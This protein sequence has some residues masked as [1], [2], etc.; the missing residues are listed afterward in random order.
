MIAYWDA[1]SLYPSQMLNYLPIGGFRVEEHANHTAYLY[2]LIDSFNPEN[3]KG[4]LICADMYV[5]AHQHDKLD[6]G[7][8][9]RGPTCEGGPNKLYSYLGPQDEYCLTL[10]LAHCYHTVLG[11]RFK[12]VHRIWR[13]RQAPY[14]REHILEMCAR[15]A[16][17]ESEIMKDTF[18]KCQNSYYGCTSENHEKRMSIVP[19]TNEYEFEQANAKNWRPGLKIEV[20]YHYPNGDFLGHRECRPKGGVELRTPRIVAVAILDYAKRHLLQF[21]YGFVKLNFGNDARL[22]YTDTDSIIVRIANVRSVHEA[23]LRDPSWFDF[24]NGRKLGWTESPEN[25]G[26]PG[27]FKFELIQKKT[28]VLQHA[29]EYAGPEA[30]CYGLR[31]WNEEYDYLR[32]KGNPQDVVKKQIQFEKVKEAALNQEVVRTNF[33]RIQMKNSEA[34]HVK[35]SKVAMRGDNGKVYKLDKE[36]F[37]PLGHRDAKIDQACKMLQRLMLRRA[38]DGWKD[39]IAESKMDDSSQ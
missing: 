25:A 28:G 6:W 18:K 17:A 2:E 21:H 32:C 9:R 10:P 8:I 4:C 7:P 11:V 33:R 36:N 31:L 15:R 1:N 22:L 26:K 14:L 24:S 34:R 39:A 37:L 16:E 23:M 29:L 12:K 38:F 30:K 27:P 3:P 13:F 19:Y 20:K 5:P 35:I